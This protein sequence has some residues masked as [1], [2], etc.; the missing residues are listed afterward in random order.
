MKNLVNLYNIPED[1]LNIDLLNRTSDKPLTHYLV[2][3]CKSL[4]VIPN[5]TFL[6]YDYENDESKIDSSSYI[7]AKKRNNEE[8]S[9]YKLLQDT[10][11]GELKLHF[12]LKCKDGIE[13]ITKSILVP[14]QDRNGYFTIRG[15]KYFLL[16][17]LVERSTY[18]TSSSVILK[19]LMPVDLTRESSSITDIEDTE[20]N[21]PIIF[22]KLFN[23]NVD[24][25][26]LYFAKMGFHETL[27][28]FSLNNA[29]NLKEDL[30]NIDNEKFIYFKLRNS[31]IE[32]NRFLFKKHSYFRMMVGMLVYTCNKVK[33]Q[34]IENKKF[35]IEKLGSMSTTSQIKMY[36]KGKTML[37][38]FE[39]MV[40]VTTIDILQV[41]NENKQSMY[42]VVR[43]AI[44]NYT[45]LKKRSN[46]DLENKRLR[47][48]EYIASILNV[49]FSKRINRIVKDSNTTLKNLKNLFKFHGDILIQNLHA[50][51]LLRFDDAVNDM[52]FFTKLR[53]T[54]KGYNSIGNKNDRNIDIALR[55]IH[56]SYLGVIDINTSGN[57]DPGTSGI[58][59]PFSKQIYGLQFTE[60][61]EP[62]DGAYMLE[63]EINNHL[64]ETLGDNFVNIHY[65]DSDDYYKKRENF[66]EIL[67]GIKK[68]DT[69]YISEDSIFIQ[70][71][72]NDEY[73][74]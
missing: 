3:I 8:D 16:Y 31:Y 17:Q 54:I 50:T 38:Y 57:S 52:D 64:N 63:T 49:E 42:S 12:R 27:R 24:I 20:Y 60:D 39:R 33:C 35:W 47:L 15:K 58:L 30:D 23:K 40:D 14:K 29:I 28:F 22:I 61:N 10:R 51:G 69:F 4:E 48:N 21:V 62:E 59:T 72:L 7:S 55:G 70:I 44:L 71:N 25:F 34:N 26:S 43:W 2:N 56:P 73:M 53:F 45:D 32:V 9:T 46:L 65:D 67:R 6:G 5:I 36:E 1:G 37:M 19:S 18:N 11:Y 66:K 41:S 68:Y 13:E 74:Y